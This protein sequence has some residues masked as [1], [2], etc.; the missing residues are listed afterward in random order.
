MCFKN[1]RFLFPAFGGLLFGYDIGAT[2]SATISIQVLPSNQLLL[3]TQYFHYIF[4]F[5]GV[6]PVYNFPNLKG[7]Q[8]FM[9]Y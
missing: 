9:L 6:A 8:I 2:S 1:L 3:P 7:S 5:N 4:H